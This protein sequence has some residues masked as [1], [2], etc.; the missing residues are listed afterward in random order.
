MIC[1][2]CGYCCQTSL[3]VIV[4]DPKKG[5]KE[6]NLKA[7]D[8]MK[9]RCPHLCGKKPGKYSCSIHKEKWY[10][11]TPCFQ[12]GQIERGNQKCRMGEHLLRKSGRPG[13][14]A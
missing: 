8:A 10:K 9:E 5:V 1:L 3:V 14:Q 7:I 12:H 13:E 4:V 2:R 11:K 6:G